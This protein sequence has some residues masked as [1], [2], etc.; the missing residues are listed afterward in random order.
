MLYPDYAAFCLS[1][2]KSCRQQVVRIGI[3]EGMI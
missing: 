2:A 3:Q 1:Y